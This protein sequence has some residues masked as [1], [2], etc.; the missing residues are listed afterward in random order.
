MLQFQINYQTGVLEYRTAAGWVDG[1][2]LAPNQWHNLKII[3]RQSNDTLQYFANGIQIFSGVLG[4][5]KNVQ[6]IDFVYD[7]FGSGFRVDNIQI[8]NLASLST[9]EA[10][11]RNIIKLFPNPAVDELQIEAEGKILLIE[12]FDAKGSF[13]K[14]IKETGISNGKSITVSD[15]ETGVYIIKVKTDAGE[16]ARKFIKK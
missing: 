2:V 10:V 13:I 16:F 8:N 15:L 9:N 1:P 5:N 11:K 6:A 4:A 7:D 12:I 14:N 3:I